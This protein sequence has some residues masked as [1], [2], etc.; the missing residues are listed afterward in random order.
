MLERLGPD[1]AK[2]LPPSWAFGEVGEPH[3]AAPGLSTLAGDIDRRSERQ[4]RGRKTRGAVSRG[5]VQQ[6]DASVLVESVG[7]GAQCCLVVALNS[8]HVRARGAGVEDTQDRKLKVF[9]ISLLQ[10][11]IATV[12]IGCVGRPPL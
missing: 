11:E 1:C 6:T 2:V 7:A 12:T 5:Y 3:V 9:P 8:V 4:A 10:L